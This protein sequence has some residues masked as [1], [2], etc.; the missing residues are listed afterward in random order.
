MKSLIAAAIACAMTMTAAAPIAAKQLTLE[1]LFQSPGLSGP[2]PREVKFS[3][4]G[5]LLTLLRNRTDDRDRYDL[6]AIDTTS[7]AEHMLVDSLKIGSGAA[8]SEEEKMRRERLRIG[9]LKGITA[10]DWAPDGK[11]VLVPLDGDLYLAALDGTVRRLTDTPQ[12]EIEAKVSPGGHFVSFVRDHNLYAIDLASGAERQLTKDGGGTLAWGT[13]EFVAQE[14]LERRSGTWW[15][16]KETRIAVQR[17]DESPVKIVRRAAIGAEGTTIVEQRYPAAGTPNALVELWLMNP[18][19]SGRVKADLGSNPDFY[20]AR[21]DWAPDGKA[22]YV[23]QLARDNKRLDLLRI[24][25]MTGAATKLIEET[26][27][28]WVDLNNDFRV[29]KD[30]SLLWSSERSGYPHLDR[31]AHGKLSPLTHGDWSVHSVAGID[32]A[33]HIYFTA[34]KDDVLETQLYAIDLAHPETPRRITESGWT[35]GASM[36]KGAT[37]IILTRSNPDQPPQTYLAD[38]TGK[39]LAWI[40][41]NKLDATHSYAPYLDHHRPTQFGT[42]KAAD[43]S[44]LHYKM[45]TPVLEP[46]KRYPVFME[47]YGGPGSQTVTR[48]WGSPIHQYLVTRGFIVFEIDN[49]GSPNRG[50]A[51]EDQIYHAMGTVEVEDQVAAAK[52]LKTQAYVD[53]ARIAT[54]GWSYGGYMTLKLLEKAPGV[55]AA[56]IA[57]APVTKWELYDTAYTE[58]YLGMPPYDTS[59]A[60]DDATKIVDPLLTLHGMADDNVVFEN[61]TALWAKLQAAKVPFE[62]MAYP[63]KTHGVSGEGAQTHVWETILGFLERRGIIAPVAK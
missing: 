51:F 58:R 42:L 23:Q 54:Y 52:W 53:P 55:F 15:S 26:S 63:G 19:G 22:L 25:P 37:R 31:F 21:V 8:L 44:I 6:W 7:G 29:L 32:A 27:K 2:S 14:E 36:D 59:D 45:I 56:G 30:G 39:R 5:K 12:T 18:D 57:G 38:V 48:A 11:S 10:Y 40:N 60:L 17:T 1:R 41:E 4:D 46:G 16:P 35:Y 20:L 24:D 43:G 50:R 28:T 9:A 47:H 61:S 34:N 3:P 49:R 13:A 33:G 62:M